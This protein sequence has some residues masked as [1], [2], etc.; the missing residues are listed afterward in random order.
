MQYQQ[1]VATLVGIA[2]KISNK[3]NQLTSHIK[4]YQTTV[5]NN[6]QPASIQ[7]VHQDIEVNNALIEDIS[8]TIH[9]LTQQQR[10]IITRNFKLQNYL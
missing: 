5:D 4:R 7:H 3:I 2:I 6:N 9:Y 8:D 1:I 10:E